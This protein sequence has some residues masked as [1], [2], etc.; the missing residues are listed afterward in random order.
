ML[1]MMTFF[2]GLPGQQPV[3]GTL[4][5][6]RR[7]QKLSST[8]EAESEASMSEASSEDLV[9][10]LEAEV[11]PDRGK[12]EAVKK[13][14]KKKPKGLANMFS[15]FTKGRKKK[16]QPSSAEPEGP[17]ESAPGLGGQPPGQLPTVEELKADLE[18]GRLETARPLL[19]LERE[20]QA[21]AAAGG[22]SQEELVRRQS[23]VEALYALLRDQ[24]LG[25][26]RRP[27]ETAPERLRQA[28][29]VLAEQEREDRQA[30]AAAAGSGPS[31]LA[32]T[33]P[34]GW[35]QLWRRDVA[36]AAEERLGRQP[37]E[38]AEGRSEAERIFL[39][40]GRTMKEDL[41]AVVER[42]KPLFPAEFGVVAAYAESYHEH[43]AAQL[44]AMAQFELCE[45]DTYMLLVWVQ[46]L[47][48][49]DIINSP[50]LA[51]ELQ[52]L[53]LGSLLPPGQIRQLEATFLSN[54]VA[55]VK[56]MM[57]RA[58]D[59]ES[60]RWAEDV[61]PQR[62]DGHCHSELAIDIIQIISQGQAKAE[63]I[64][65]ELGLQIKHMLLVELAAF[66]KSYQHAF[67]EFLERCKQ[68]RNYRANVIANINNCLS[69]RTS[70]EQKWQTS[71]DLPSHLL[72]PLSELKSHSFDTLLQNLFGDLK[73][74]F[75][76]FTQTRWAAPTQTL[77]EII[78][79]VGKRLPEFSEL[80]DCF[81]Q[82]LMEVV[83]LHLVKEYIIRLSKRRLVLK[84]AEQQEELAG[85]IL[86][87]AQLIQVFCTQN[88]SPAAWLHH[89]LPTLAEIIRLQ[90]PSAIKIEVATYA[91]SYP[92]FSKGHLSAIL[93]IK[94]NLSNSDVKSIRS[95]LD[96]DM[97]VHQPFKS[98]FS[99]IKVG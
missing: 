61:A 92:D 93:A 67:G 39:H 62:L 64:N 5:F 89:A 95:I 91:T 98:L 85:H 1:K 77:E 94:G 54:E 12:E 3:P 46:N 31:V 81:R 21:A 10:P 68:L 8:S 65:L 26:L 90:D 52:A 9:P 83:H 47:Y 69:F 43:F 50:K 73:P 22:A 60:Q 82:E 66:L 42:L 78:S 80:H 74:L 33:R 51:H 29:A 2:Q 87:N 23:K 15:V 79:T 86:A 70:M 4:D 63:S 11:A 16:G 37:A 40:M 41:E 57:A 49:N 99:L 44:A 34:R 17:P 20:L 88:G 27:L 76:K 58:L 24:V 30:A 36:Q 13:K 25:L 48:P 53:G 7:P 72:G 35:L 96:I 19:A 59:L 6:P 55:S 14:K 28:L 38:G 32:A 97:G 56:E 45:R 71:Q 84:T 75:K 18:R